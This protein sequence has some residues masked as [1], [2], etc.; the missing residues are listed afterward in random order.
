MMSLT[1]FEIYL[2]IKITHKLTY[3]GIHF[4]TLKI[5]INFNKIEDINVNI[6]V[7]LNLVQWKQTA[8]L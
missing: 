8:S 5:R 1:K 6:T 4:E 7:H 2:S 3:N